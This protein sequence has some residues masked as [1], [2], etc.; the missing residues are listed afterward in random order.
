MDLCAMY[1]A[2]KYY[3]AFLW[4]PNLW[5]ESMQVGIMNKTNMKRNVQC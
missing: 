5:D 1:V 4:L 3:K 2:C